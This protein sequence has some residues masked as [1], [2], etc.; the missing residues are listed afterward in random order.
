MSLP[1]SLCEVCFYLL[2]KGS[3]MHFKIPFRNGKSEYEI[4]I[5]AGLIFPLHLWVMDTETGLT[6]TATRFMG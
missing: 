5:F 3:I 2:I 1:A 4:S 6:L